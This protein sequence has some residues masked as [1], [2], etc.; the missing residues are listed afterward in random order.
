MVLVDGIEMPAEIWDKVKFEQL[1]WKRREF[2]W[3]G[4]TE[5]SDIQQQQH[6]QEEQQQLEER[7][8]RLAPQL[9]LSTYHRSIH[10]NI[11]KIYII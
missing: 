6:Q 5:D 7:G 2:D 10:S 1:K 4:D 11:F 9:H 8:L 3:L